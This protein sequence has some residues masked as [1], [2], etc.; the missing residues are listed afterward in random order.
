MRDNTK[1]R[2]RRPLVLTFEEMCAVEELIR[3]RLRI[4][5]EFLHPRMRKGLQIRA[6][7]LR[8]ISAK[9]TKI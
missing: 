3:D 6:G 9:L 2:H 7:R 5:D 4:L 1:L 8:A